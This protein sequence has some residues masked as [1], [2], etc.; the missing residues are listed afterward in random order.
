[1]AGEKLGRHIDLSSPRG[2]YLDYSH[3]AG[4]KPECDEKGI[5]VVRVPGGAR[6]C[7]PALAA[8][9]ALGHLEV[10]LENGND[11][12]RRRFG[13]LARW[14]IDGMEVLPGSYGGWSM[15]LV[16][17][18][19]RG[20]LREGWFSASAHAECIAVLVR[21]VSLLRLDG[22]LESARRAIGA[23]H[24]S[25]E[26]GGFLREVG[27]AGTDSGVESLAFIEEYPL[28]GH[29]RMVLGSHVKAMWA[30]HDY[31]NVDED[32]GARALF[33]RCVGGLV[34]SLDRFDLGYWSSASL[35]GRRI[36]PA[37]AERH[38]THAL[39]LEV[40]HGMT[41]EPA[42]AE[43]ARLWRGYAEDA[44]NRARAGVERARAALANA[45]SPTAP[46]RD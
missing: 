11:A 13:D 4:A 43:R 44:R 46:E 5:P 17:R 25:V 33:R 37:S 36:R 12:R 26:D 35:D 10:Y 1:M 24:T 8:R 45:G 34:F 21:A 9:A 27:E 20:E 3:L 14:L 22:A 2:Y 28:A 18:R 39:M 32:P 29:P 15:P 19:L 42:F 30:I 41:D 38:G 16:P 23:F 6:A 40:L 31:L 7:S